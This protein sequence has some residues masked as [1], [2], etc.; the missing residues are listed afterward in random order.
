MWVAL[1]SF[2]HHHEHHEHY[3]HH[4]YNEHHESSWLFS[5]TPGILHSG[6]FYFTIRPWIGIISSAHYIGVSISFS[7]WWLR[8][9]ILQICISCIML[10][11]TYWCDYLYH[12][13]IIR[14][15]TIIFIYNYILHGNIYIPYHNPLFNIPIIPMIIPWVDRPVRRADACCRFQPAAWLGR[16]EQNWDCF[17]GCNWGYNIIR[18]TMK[19]GCKGL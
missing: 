19:L 5:K 9:N 15:G 2:D 4:R 7:Y 14:E 3:E 8:D 10:C 13:G 1:K 18:T 11:P 17:Y 12:M 16:W 6:W